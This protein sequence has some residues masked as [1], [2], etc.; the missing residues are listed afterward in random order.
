MIFEFLQSKRVGLAFALPPIESLV[1]TQSKPIIIWQDPKIRHN[2]RRL[3]M[4]LLLYKTK[5]L[6][7]ITCITRSLETETKNRELFQKFP[8]V[9]NTNHKHTNQ[10]N[11]KHMLFL[12]PQAKN[13]KDKTEIPNKLT[14]DRPSYAT[15]RNSLDTWTYVMIQYLEFLL[16]VKLTV[17]N[18]LPSKQTKMFFY[19]RP[20][21]R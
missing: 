21:L 7:L 1:L 18:Y 13:Q 16:F 6:F 4:K 14:P 11:A 19:L 8:C 5:G 12:H 15:N 20:I 10:S 3:F 17:K 2:A 9:V